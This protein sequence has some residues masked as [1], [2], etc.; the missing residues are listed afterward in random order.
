MVIDSRATLR[1]LPGAWF[2]PARAADLLG[3]PASVHLRFESTLRAAP[4][5]EDDREDS[6]AVLGAGDGRT[7]HESQKL[8]SGTNL[9]RRGADRGDAMRYAPKS[10][11]TSWRF[12]VG[13]LWEAW[14]ALRCVE[15]GE[16][17][18]VCGSQGAES[19][20]GRRTSSVEIKYA[21]HD[22]RFTIHDSRN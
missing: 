9:V 18:D 19:A 16:V 11:R 12:R 4:R 20:G 15:E 22:S 7:C 21:I 17:E 8:V 5:V 1:A 10:W 13:N 14:K 3:A 6:P 2:A